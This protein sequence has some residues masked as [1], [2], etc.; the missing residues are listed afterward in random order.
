MIIKILGIFIFGTIETYI[1]TGWN[2]SANKRQKWL[3]SLLMFIYMVLYLAIIDIAFKD[4]N[5]K[6]M[7]VD[8]AMACALGNYLRINH[9]KKSKRNKKR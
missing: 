2:L 4:S 9:E 8:Y 5:S 6:L 1:Y 7:I 3:S